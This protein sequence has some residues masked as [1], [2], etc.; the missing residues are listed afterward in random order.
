MGNLPSLRVD[1]SLSRGKLTVDSTAPTVDVNADSGVAFDVA[2]DD[3]V[4]N[5]DV[6]AAEIDN[7]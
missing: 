7:R 6:G 3:P 4:I 1:I 5:P 2:F